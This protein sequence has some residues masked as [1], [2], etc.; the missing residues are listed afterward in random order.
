MKTGMIAHD[1]SLLDSEG[2]IQTL[3]AFYGKPIVLYFYPKDNTPGCTKQACGFRD[4]FDIFDELGITVIGISKDTVESHRKFK[5]EH[6]LPFI[7]LSDLDGKVVE[8]YGVW[9]EKSMY[10]KTYMGI[11]RSTFVIDASGMISHVFEQASPDT[12]A[13]DIIEA[14][15]QSN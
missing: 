7:L 5:E 4:H 9:V 15:R 14:F 6:Q 10:G 12:N 8:K 11:K 3:S 1:F 13:L 2:N